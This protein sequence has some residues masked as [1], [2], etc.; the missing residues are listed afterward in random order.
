MRECE[1][2][3]GMNKRAFALYL[4]LCYSSPRIVADILEYNN[5]RN[6]TLRELMNLAEGESDFERQEK[7]WNQ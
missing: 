6:M 3:S 5:P 2:A 1:K 4:N 7:V